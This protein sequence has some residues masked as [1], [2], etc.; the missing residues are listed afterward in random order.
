MYNIDIW[1]GIMNEIVRNCRLC[2]QPMKTSPFRM[3]KVC[4][5][6]S[7]KVRSYVRKYPLV[8]MK[9]IAETTNVSLEKIEDMVRLNFS[10]Q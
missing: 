4:L 10:L 1:G 2:K 6:E 3:C 5:I 9:Q 8:S 7:E